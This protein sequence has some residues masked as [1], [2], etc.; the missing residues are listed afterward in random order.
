MTHVMSYSPGRVPMRLQSRGPGEGFAG[1][2]RLGG[3]SAEGPE[4]VR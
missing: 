4:G 3:D 2:P 1:T